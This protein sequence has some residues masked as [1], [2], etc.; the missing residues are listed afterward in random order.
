M[1]DTVLRVPQA[2]RRMAMQKLQFLTTQNTY[3][4]SLRSPHLTDTTPPG[5]DE[6]SQRQNLSP[7]YPHDVGTSISSKLM[8]SVLREYMIVNDGK[9]E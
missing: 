5:V 8:A 9:A 2:S 1:H 4:R 6:L 3:S 7:E